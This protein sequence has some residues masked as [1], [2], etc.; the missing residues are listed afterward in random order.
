MVA[1]LAGIFT[2]LTA[3]PSPALLLAQPGATAQD[4][5][6]S[7][8]W[9]FDKSTY[10]NDPKTGHRVDQ[11]KHEKTPYRDPN[12]IFDSSMGSP[13]FNDSFY[14]SSDFNQLY[15]YELMPEMFKNEY[16]G[17]DGSGYYPYDG[18]PNDEDN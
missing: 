17:E 5:D 15:Y 2:F 4:D 3:S 16:F 18:D 6:A 9:M 1:V 7:G 10:T 13:F 12:A 8:D 11:Y 14:G